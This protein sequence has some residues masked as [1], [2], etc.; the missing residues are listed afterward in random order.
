MKLLLTSAMT[1]GLSCASIAASLV[2]VKVLNPSDR[3]FRISYAADALTGRQR[4][5]EV[6][7]RDDDTAA[8]ELELPGR[9]ELLMRYAG[10]AIPLYVGADDE[11]SLEF[12]AAGGLASVKFGGSAATDNEFLTAFAKTFPSEGTAER[13]GGF[14]P[15]GVE[16]RDLAEAAV[17]DAEAFLDYVTAA[18]TRKTAL[19]DG[20]DGRVTVQLLDRYR[21]RVRWQ[22]E[23]QKIGFLL[24]NQL[25]KSREELAAAAL[26]LK[27]QPLPSDGDPGKLEDE[28]FKN[29]LKA[30]AQYLVLPNRDAHDEAAGDALYA[31]AKTIERRWRHYLQSEL[32]VNAFDYLGS[33][34]FGLD[35]YV[36]LRRDG[37][38]EVFRKRIED[39]YGD[40]L[41]LLP[42]ALAPN[43]GMYEVH[44]KPMS[45][46]D[47]GGSVIYI[48]F[49]ASWC[50]PCIQ[51]FERYDAIRGQLQEKGVVLLNVDIDDEE[52]DWQR[53][54]ER[55]RPRGLNVRGTQL[56]ELKRAYNLV[57]IPAYAIID[58][59]GRIVVLPQGETRDLLAV[60]DA[61]LRS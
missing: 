11:L 51:N 30:Y 29:Y 46:S 42:G 56:K 15:F 39:A 45:L 34:S 57:T 22:A 48:S 43:I 5:F 8:F 53:A 19:I 32:L 1:V 60:F 36:E 58:K 2:S 9:T 3:S 47:L 12:D 13:G 25:L 27:V 16:K 18:A 55:V 7:L 28:A 26:E 6:K 23:V 37:L 59:S 31:A 50:K 10:V 52:S 38:Q 33:P 54:L 49:W 21:D 44:G 20:Y 35:R 61:I 24:Q 14:L 40:V 4:I 41:N 17:V